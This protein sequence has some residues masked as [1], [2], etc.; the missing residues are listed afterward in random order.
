MALNNLTDQNIQDTYQKVVQTDGTN[1]ADGTG[2][3][4]PIKFDGPDLIVSGALRANSYIVSESITS[5]SSGSTVFGNSPDDTHSFIGNISASTTIEGASLRG[6]NLTLGRVAFAGTDGLLVDDSTLTF[7]LA[8]LTATN[9]NVSTATATTVA[10]STLASQ[11]RSAAAEIADGTGVMTIASSVLTTTDING[12]TIDGATIA[13][14]NITVGSGKS[15]DVALGLFETSGEQNLS[16][17]QG[18]SANIDIGSYELRAATLESDIATGTAPL[19]V[20]STTVVENLNAEKFS[21]ADLVDEDDMTSDSATKVPTQQ[22]VKAY[23]DTMLP[24]AGGTM[25]G[26]VNFGDQDITNVDSLDADKLSI[27]GGT[28]MTAV[29]DEDNMASNSATALATQQSIKAYVDVVSEGISLDGTTGYQIESNFIVQPTTI[30]PIIDGGSVTTGTIRGKQINIVQAHF[31][32]NVG[33]TKYFLPIAGVPDEQTAPHREG[34]VIIAPCTGKLL[35]AIVRTD[36]PHDDP[37]DDGIDPLSD[38]QCI[39][40]LVARPKNKMLNGGYGER[41]AVTFTGPNSQNLEDGNTVLVTFTDAASFTYGEALGVSIQF[42][43]TG[44]TE[45][46]DRLYVTLVFEYDYTTLGY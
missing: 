32:K 14:S 13:T 12:G 41:E 4:L 1:L 7:G 29:N 28:E 24:L 35:R 22:S 10:T 23:A 17:I 44:M 15:L 30:S 40:T 34:T 26:A 42:Q 46:A 6:D 8:T 2:S 16:I 3:A 11:N 31:K 33:T 38:E 37:N 5:V 9:I 20:A 45:A 25:T 21:G 18:A 27:A 19:T 39:M 43:T 36:V